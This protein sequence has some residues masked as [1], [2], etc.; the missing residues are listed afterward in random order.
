ML[1]LAAVGF[2]RAAQDFFVAPQA[3]G[4]GTG[5]A[6]ETAANFRDPT[7]W[8]QVNPALQRGPVTVTF[9]AGQYLVSSDPARAMPP[10]TLTGLGHD[11]HR[12]VLQGVRGGDVVFTRHPADR[13]AG[14]KGP[15]FLFLSGCHNAVV[16]QLTFTAPHVPIGYATNFGKCR[17]ILIEDCHWHDL[18]GVYYGATGTT[19]ATT[20]HITYRR[21]RFERVG[22]GGHAHMAYNAYDPRHLR[23]VDC[24]FEDCAGDY[25]RFRDNTD[26]GVVTGCT[27][28][29][30]GTYRNTHAPFI[31]IP[32]FNDDNPARNPAHP[33]YEYFG[34]HFLICHNTFLYATAAKPEARIAVLFHQSGFSPPGRHYLLTPAEGRVLRTG[35]TGEKKAL[36]RETVGI[37]PGTV[38]VFG[39]THTH[40]ALRGAYRCAAQYG[41]KSLGGDGLYDIGETFNAAPVVDS[42]AAAL[43]FF[44]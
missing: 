42:A 9:L 30:T 38:H 28:R 37:D 43:E 34:T 3:V 19:D 6:A 11:T 21:C 27:F 15:G 22:S 2:A 10:L 36:L 4:E 24:L 8:A 35:T 25:V 7:L 16:R 26:Y 33:N 40:V 32:L 1:V 18:Q 23:Y 14:D 5:A 13:R 41:A 20:D 44:K 12:F 39:N 29:S 31:A 17:N